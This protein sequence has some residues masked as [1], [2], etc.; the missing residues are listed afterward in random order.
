[1][2]FNQ[3]SRP[4][5][6]NFKTDCYSCFC[7]GLKRLSL[8]SSKVTACW[9]QIKQN[10]NCFI[11]VSQMKERLIPNVPIIRLCLTDGAPVSAPDFTPGRFFGDYYRFHGDYDSGAKR[12]FWF[13][14]PDYSKMTSPVI[15]GCDKSALVA[16]TER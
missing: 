8:V 15:Q 16:K 13:F 14:R 6:Y 5:I 3:G 7:K 11:S 10:V 1:M 9:F 2:L 12:Y 4:K